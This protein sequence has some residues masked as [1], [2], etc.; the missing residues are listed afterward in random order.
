MR[1]LGGRG[2]A[3]RLG[4]PVGN[5]RQ[6]FDQFGLWR[7]PTRLLWNGYLHQALNQTMLLQKFAKGYQ[8]AMLGIG[9]WPVR[10]FCGHRLILRAG[11]YSLVTRPY[12]ISNESTIRAMVA[13]NLG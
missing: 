8:G 5:A 1:F 4:Y 10:S 2:A 7:K 3:M 12:R 6:E 13:Q 9:R 11:G